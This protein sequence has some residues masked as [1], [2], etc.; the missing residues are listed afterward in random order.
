[1]GARARAERSAGV[2]EA[3]E[4]I[5]SFL[6]GL[7]FSAELVSAGSPEFPVHRCV[8]RDPQGRP[9][10][11]SLGKG[12]GEQSRASALFEAWQHL[13]HQRGQAALAADPRRV[14]VLAAS[15]VVAQPQ[16]RGEGMLHRL[17]A[18]YPDARL[19]CLRLEPM[20]QGASELWYPAFARS[21]VCRDHPIPGDDLEYEPYLRYAYDSGTAT[22]MSE[23]EALLHGLLEAVERDALSHAL[24]NWYVNDTYRPSGVDPADL[25]ADISRLYEYATDRFGGP[26]LLIDMTSDLEI[27]AYCALPPRARHPGVLG[28]GAS[29]DAEYALERALTEVVQSEFNMS[30]GVD[31]TLGN[32]LAYL[33]RWPLL[34]RCARADPAGLADRLSRGGRLPGRAERT[35]EP[36]VRRRLAAVLERLE[37]AGF[38]AYSFRWNPS[39]PGFPVVTV[40]V[41]GL[42]TFAMVHNAVPVLP[43]GRAARLL[44]GAR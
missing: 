21:P 1:M 44:A 39:G 2:G 37:R 16:L 15:T 32:R 42:D 19:A 26:P 5:E 29:L 20:A 11:E 38:T 23:P 12:A 36:G 43:T 27:P 10:A 41:P 30:L 17:A 33:R 18:D 9:V 24:L 3:L 40:V 35:G 6:T 13:Q 25:P 31:R 4:S 8:L 34:E 7:G 28:S 14:R 22:G